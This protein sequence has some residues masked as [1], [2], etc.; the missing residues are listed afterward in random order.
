MIFVTVGFGKQALLAPPL[1]WR[2]AQRIKIFMIASGNHTEMYSRH[3]FS[4]D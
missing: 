4:R 3:G 1:G 2:S